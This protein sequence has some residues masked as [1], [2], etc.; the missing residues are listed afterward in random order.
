MHFDDRLATVLRSRSSGASM[1]RIQFRQ[2]LDLLG[3]LPVESEGAQIDAACDRLGELA[4]VIP[5]AERAAMLREPGMRLRNPRLVALLAGGEPSVA[6]A[7]IAAA[8]LGEEEWLDLAPALPA[9]ARALVG[10]RRDMGPRATALFARL[11]MAPPGLPGVGQEPAVAVA[12]PRTAG[13]HAGDIGEIVQR[14][15][16]FR[17]K[18]EP[19]EAGEGSSPQSA[20]AAERAPVRL[21]AFDFATDAEGCIVWSDPG[22]APMVL[23]L[24]LASHDMTAPAAARATL[25]LALRHRQPL[26]RLVMELAGA[27]A[28]AGR[29]QIDAV[30]CF[31]PGS[32][33]YTGHAGRMRRQTAPVSI[34]RPT[35][36]ES[37]A[38][39][40]RQLL[41]ELRTPVNAIQGFA[42][43]I[44][45]QLFGPAPHEYRA[46][47]ANV[48]GDAARVLAGLEELE[49]LAQLESGRL[50]LEADGS[51][52]A[53]I[54]TGAV[55]QLRA[56]T[57]PRGGGFD[58]ALPD[59]ESL[60]VAISKDDAE[61]LIWRLLAT[62][63][64]AAAPGE[65][66]KLRGRVRGDFALITIALPQ[67]LAALDDEL[68][69][70]ALAGSASRALSAGIF[71]AGFSLR[72]AR[73]EAAAAGGELRRKDKRLKLSLPGLT[74][75]MARHSQ[76]RGSEVRA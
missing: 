9:G 53:A 4:G 32:G 47:A 73:A 69:W 8:Q 49:R 24:R 46:L 58:L 44:Q 37:D 56:F 19:V 21:K 60:P 6:A 66:L 1:A 17:K 72:L 75:G 5:A 15:E 2:L 18:R 40:M 70:Q 39:R 50:T 22:M 42:E 54:L 35:E 34:P 36:R 25:A 65:M 41:H 14:I 26:R 68:L 71:G 57:E 43:V 64:G 55:A 23:G 31:E 11:G 67:S 28:I 45:Q 10:Q 63:A 62:L 59:S 20:S 29:W 38:D 7:T 12:E 51:E 27:P 3:T 16:D 74:G 61:R 33:A 30:P 13:S 76:E 52:L 48:A